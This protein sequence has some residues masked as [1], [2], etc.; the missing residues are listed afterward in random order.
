M[1]LWGYWFFEDI[2]A[3]KIIQGVG[4]NFNFYLAI[5]LRGV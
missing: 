1:F 4:L 5:L 2:E 3:Y